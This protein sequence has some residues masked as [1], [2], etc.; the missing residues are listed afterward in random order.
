MPIYVYQCSRC[1]VRTELFFRSMN[2]GAREVL[3]ES[4]GSADV[5]RVFTPFAIYRSEL[6]KLQQLDPMYYKKVDDAIKHTPEADPIRHI[7]KM[8]DFDSTPDPGKPIEF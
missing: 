6:T 4:C 7:K 3:C 8:Q 2:T 1:D 5:E